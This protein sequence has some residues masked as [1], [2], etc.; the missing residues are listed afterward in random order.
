LRKGLLFPTA[1]AIV[2]HL[3]Q[4]L[5]GINAVFYYS[6]TILRDAGVA[7]AQYT[8]PFIGLILVGATLISLPLMELKGRRFLHLLGLAGMFAFSLVMTA[9]TVLKY[10]WIKYLNV[11]GMMCYIFFFAIGPGSQVFLLECIWHVFLT[12]TFFFV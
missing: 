5:S 12:D 4:Q 6:E 11:V 1:V 10:E 3:S 7:N 2:L 9:A 8:T